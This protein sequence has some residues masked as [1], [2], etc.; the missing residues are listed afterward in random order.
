MSNQSFKH[1]GM[2]LV[3]KERLQD[4]GGVIAV[5]EHLAHQP[6][7]NGDEYIAEA[8]F[9]FNEDLPEAL[10]LASP[11]PT[12]AAESS[13]QV[14]T[15][16]EEDMTK[17]A[18]FVTVKGERSRTYSFV[19]AQDLVVTGVVKFRQEADGSHRLEVATGQKLFVQGWTVLLIDS[20][21]WSF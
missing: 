15:N 5:P 14:A 7:K 2:S 21:E 13:V 4:E 3:I 1:D 20:D 6:F 12:T 9:V 10:R 16:T 11:I 19:G 17:I 18:D 8:V